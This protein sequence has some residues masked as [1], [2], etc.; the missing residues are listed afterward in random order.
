[1]VFLRERQ[2]I[3]KAMNI[4]DIPV[5]TM[6]IGE[7]IPGYDF[8]YKG[9]S[10]KVACKSYRDVYYARCTVEMFGDGVNKDLHGTPWLYKDI[11]LR[12]GCSCLTD[13]FGYSDVMEMAEWNNARTVHAGDPV[14]L[15]FYDGHNCIIRKMKVSERVDR[16]C[17][18][19]ATLEDID[20]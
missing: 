4:D 3:A 5:L 16:G 1:M 2:E 20:E 10:V 11:S 13:S 6:N 15:V 17:Y 9:S 7:A 18:T 8:C 14:L 19:V 12:R